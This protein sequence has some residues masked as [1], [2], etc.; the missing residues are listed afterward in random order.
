MRIC[1]KEN[2]DE[3]RKT[4]KNRNF[5]KSY[6]RVYL[7]EWFAGN[8][9]MTPLLRIEILNDWILNHREIKQGISNFFFGY[10]R[11]DKRKKEREREQ[12]LSLSSK[13]LCP[14]FRRL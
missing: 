1:S 12:T 3:I 5:S 8:K 10:P 11:S 9:L 14:S 6:S 7:T 4:L 2:L 13:R